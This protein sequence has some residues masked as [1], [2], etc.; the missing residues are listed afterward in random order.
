MFIFLLFEI[1][2][3]I[4]VFAAIVTIVVRASK[5]INKSAKKT[6]NSLPDFKSELSNANDPNSFVN[7]NQDLSNYCEYCG[8]KYE[9]VKK[10]CPSCGARAQK[11]NDVK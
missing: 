3:F 7:S 9:R 10:R 1:V 4:I 2:P 8:S 5:S 6:G 11:N